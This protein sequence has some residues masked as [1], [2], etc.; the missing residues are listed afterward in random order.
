MFEQ[1]TSWFSFV[2]PKTIFTIFHLLG[3]AIG[4]GGAYMSDAIFFSSIKDREINDTE[5]RFIKIGSRMVWAGLILLIISGAL[6][7]FNGS[8]EAYLHSSKFVAKMTIVAILTL[9]GIFFHTVHIRRLLSHRNELL[10]WPNSF[11][12]ESRWLYPS[13]A[14]SMVSWTSAIVLGAFRSVPWSYTTIMLVYCG[15]VL[16]AIIVSFIMRSHFLS[17]VLPRKRKA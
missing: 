11:I 7:F 4:A 13:G 3:V 14:I 1:V 9:N 16:F 17:P 8:P 6:L 5:L 2:E 10:V 12:K 15:I